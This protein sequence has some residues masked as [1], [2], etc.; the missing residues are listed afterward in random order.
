LEGSF[1][2]VDVVFAGEVALFWSEESTEG[3]LDFDGQVTLFFAQDRWLLAS[4]RMLLES[5]LMKIELADAVGTRVDLRLGL[6][7][8]IL[9]VSSLSGATVATNLA[10]AASSALASPTSSGS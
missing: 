5:E 10:T 3:F 6:G 7:L 4:V 8:S 1:T 9:V 2:N